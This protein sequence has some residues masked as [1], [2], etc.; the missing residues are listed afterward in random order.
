MAAVVAIFVLLCVCYCFAKIE[1]QYPN[2]LTES[3][4]VCLVPGR[5]YCNSQNVCLK[6]GRLDLEVRDILGWAGTRQC[7]RLSYLEEE[8]KLGK[9]LE[10]G[11]WEHRRTQNT[12]TI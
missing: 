5:L 7:G 12:R 10:E 3:K 8:E 2:A 6:E 4:P 1:F 11:S 9:Y